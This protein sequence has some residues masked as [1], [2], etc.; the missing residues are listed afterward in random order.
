MS[1]ISFRKLLLLCVLNVFGE[2]NVT[3]THRPG[4]NSAGK[5]SVAALSSEKEKKMT[6]FHLSSKVLRRMNDIT[7]RQM[8]QIFL[9]RNNKTTST[10]E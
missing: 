8:T 2:T 9:S 4:S 1:W 6:E 10:N 5:S 3:Q 7:C